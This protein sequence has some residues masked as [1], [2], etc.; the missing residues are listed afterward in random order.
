MIKDGRWVSGMLSEFRAIA[1]D[2]ALDKAIDAARRAS[3]ALLDY[4]A[5]HGSEQTI[6]I[7]R[8][9]AHGAGLQSPGLDNAI[10]TY[11]AD[12]AID[13]LVA[14]EM[15]GPPLVSADWRSRREMFLAFGSALWPRTY[16]VRPNDDNFA[17]NVT[18]RI[19]AL[20]GLPPCSSGFDQTT[21]YSGAAR[22]V[23]GAATTITSSH[24]FFAAMAST[25][26]SRESYEDVRVPWPAFMINVPSGCLTTVAGVDYTWI[27]FCVLRGILARFPDGSSRPTQYAT[28][29]LMSDSSPDTLHVQKVS[30]DA[31]AEVLFDDLGSDGSLSEEESRIIASAKRAAVGLLYTMQHTN[32]FRA[33]RSPRREASPG[34]DGPPTHRNIFIGAPLSIDCRPALA[35]FH[36]HGDRHAPPSVQTLVRGHYKRQVIGV[37]R[38][39]RK[40][41]WVEPYWRGPECAPI[42]SRPRAVG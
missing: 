39:G 8:D 20:D 13:I 4:K 29:H 24:K 19:V 32:N 40:V 6:G 36:A 27:F 21:Q 16:A 15:M 37:S 12:D 26:L 1:G 2:V 31:V 11:G 42:L 14:S 38:G 35:D 41:I 10:A 25:T 28:L 7:M 33:L 17:S 22:W 34:R 3:R 23:D 9:G 30:D 18:H 5:K